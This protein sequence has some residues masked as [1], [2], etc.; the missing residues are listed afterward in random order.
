MA[1][2]DVK[3]N[4]IFCRGIHPDVFCKK[5]AL[6]N[7]TKRTGNHVY[8]SHFLKKISGRRPAT[9]FKKRLMRRFFSVKFLKLQNSFFIEQP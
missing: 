4:R 9:L 6:N 7:L 1:E 8:R 5:G 2:V 3:N